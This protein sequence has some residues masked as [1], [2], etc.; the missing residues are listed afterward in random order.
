MPEIT[1]TR[2]DSIPSRGRNGYF[3]AASASVGVWWQDMFKHYPADIFR[4]E[5]F[6]HR[7]G[8]RPPIEVRLTRADMKKLHA[9]IG[10]ALREKPTRC[11]KCAGVLGMI[12]RT[13]EGRGFCCQTVKERGRA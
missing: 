9:A 10:E 7:M 1:F 11:V 12:E 5:V 8:D 13:V 6:A 3:M 2:H 4:L